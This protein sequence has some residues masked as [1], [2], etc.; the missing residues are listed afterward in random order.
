MDRGNGKPRRRL[1]T[2]EEK[3]K[4]VQETLA[5]DVSVAE[6]ARRH[7]LNANLLCTWRRQYQQGVLESRTRQPRAVKL[8]PVKVAE[9]GS[10]PAAAGTIEIEWPDKVRVRLVGEVSSEQLEAVLAALAQSR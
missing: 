3:T 1:R 2:V 10:R 9:P 8:L 4:I 7:G 6:V 5:P